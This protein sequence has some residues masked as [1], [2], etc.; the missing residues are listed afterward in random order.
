M[1]VKSGMLPKRVA[2]INAQGRDSMLNRILLYG[3]DKTLLMTRRLI[4][5]KEGYRVFTAVEFGDA[6]QAAMTQRLDVLILCQTLSVEECKGVLETTR[7]IAPSL[8][9]IILDHKDTIDPISTREERLEV[10]TGPKALLASIDGMLK[11]PHE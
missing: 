7:E 2:V 3:K 4:L 8:K 5:E 10:L 1:I 6:I 9:V 11:H